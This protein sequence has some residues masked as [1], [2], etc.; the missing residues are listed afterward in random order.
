MALRSLTIATDGL[1]R[2]PEGT[3]PLIIAVRGLLDVDVGFK[4]II[5][6]L[7]HIEQAKIFDVRC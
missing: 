5:A 4:D 2:A 6:F 3:L 7:L 1:L